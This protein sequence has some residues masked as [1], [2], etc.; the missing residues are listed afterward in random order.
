VVFTL[1]FS[2]SPMNSGTWISAPVSTVAGLVP[3]LER[4]P[5]EARLGVGDGQDDGSRQLDG[6]RGAVVE[7]HD[8]VGAFEQELGLVA[9]QGLRNE[10]LVVGGH[11]HEDEVVAVFIGVLEVAVVDG[12]EFHLHAR[13]EGLVD[14]LAGKHVLDGGAH[15]GGALARL[16]VLE[17]D[18][19]PQLAIEVQNRT[20]LDVIGSLCQ[21]NSPIS[22][23]DGKA[24]KKPCSLCHGVH[25][26]ERCPSIYKE[27]SL[28]FS[29]LGGFF[30]TLV[31]A[32]LDVG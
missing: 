4:L 7:G 3:A 28:G 1:T 31:Q 29:S 17:L 16:D 11:V 19:G 13:V 25:T 21:I 32:C 6:Q 15:E 27:T 22:S 12:F 2:P 14:D 24:Y 23:S 8:A 10:D 9:D 20:V 30:K 5:C 18:D 26:L